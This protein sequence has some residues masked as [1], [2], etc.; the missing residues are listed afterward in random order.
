MINSLGIKTIVRSKR[1]KKARY[2]ITNVSMKD[3]SNIINVFEK[4]PYKVM[5]GRV[6][7]M[8]PSTVTFI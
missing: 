6:P 4:L 1:N 7:N 5:Y 8:N 2:Y 3:L